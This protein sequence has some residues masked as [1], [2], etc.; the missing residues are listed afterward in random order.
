MSAP[1]PDQV[2]ALPYRPCVGVVLINANGLIF[3][4]QRIDTP[5]AWQMPQGGIDEG[6]DPKAAALRELQE[7][8]GVTPDLACIEAETPDWI[9][10]DL[11]PHLQGKVWKGRYRGQTQK[12][13]LIRFHGRD[14]Q[15]NIAL[16]HPEFSRWKWMSAPALLNAIV[17][18][19]RATYAQVFSAFQTQLTGPA[20][21]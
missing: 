18:F 4:G 16:E 2:A 1:S 20:T 8:T 3:G 13:F 15:I 14:D 5:E 6:E 11:P 7:E 12:W 9:P 19:K 21:R 17:P 10:Y